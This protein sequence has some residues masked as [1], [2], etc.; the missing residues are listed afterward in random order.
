MILSSV[1]SAPPPAKPT[2]TVPKVTTPTPTATPTT[3]PTSTTDFVIPSSSLTPTPTPN[4]G[5]IPGNATAG[6]CPPPLLPNIYSLD[7]DSCK[8]PCCL[9]CPA[10]SVFY[11][12]GQLET[13]YTITSYLRAV[14]AVS[15]LLLFLAYVVLPSRRKHPHLLVL[16]FAA[17]MVPFEGL[18]T[19]WLKQKEE[20][21]CKN[22]YE[23]TT[24]ANSWFCGVQG[25][26]FMYLVLTILCLATLLITNL[27]LLTV[28]RSALIQD[29]LG[30]LMVLSFFLPLSL[31]LP[32]ALRKQI[33]NPGFGSVCFVSPE[34]ASAY[35][36]LPLSVMVCIATLLHLWTIAF[37]IKSRIQAN[38]VSVGD[39]TS[40]N[41]SDTH[42]NKTLSVRQRRLQTA[43]DISHLLKQQWRPGLL[44]LCLL[45]TDMIYWLFYFTEAKKL[46]KIDASTQWFLQ[47]TQCL[48]QQ[49]LLSIQSGTLPLT[50]TP[51]PAEFQAAGEV[52][53][54]ACASIAEPFVPNFAWAVLAEM[55]P[56]SFG[57]AILFIF[58]T[59]LE[60]WQD[61]R[62]RLWGSKDSTVFIM[63][64]IS[65]DTKDKNSQVQQQ[66]Q[67]QSGQHKPQYNR[68]QHQ[69]QQTDEFY[70]DDLILDQNAYGSRDI[71]A[72]A[73]EGRYGGK[74]PR[75]STSLAGSRTSVPNAQHAK[76]SG[77]YGGPVRKTSVCIDDS[78]EPIYYRP[79]SLENAKNNPAQRQQQQ[80]YLKSQF[81]SDEIHH[82]EYARNVTNGS[83]PW[84]SWPS[85]TRAIPTS[86]NGEMMM[87]ERKPQ[88]TIKTQRDSTY[89]PYQSSIVSPRVTSPMSS[90]MSAPMS[91]PMSPHK[92]FYNSDDLTAPPIPLT[93]LSSSTRGVTTSVD[94]EPLAIPV[95]GSSRREQASSSSFSSD[96]ASRSGKYPSQPTSPTSPTR[97]FLPPV[98]QKSFRRS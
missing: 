34:I 2:T 10:S 63:G 35:F 51:T 62:V 41:P 24:M 71:L 70:S 49:A 59:K 87:A 92:A 58:G 56:A 94:A 25:I 88:P 73:T 33:Q 40:N 9:P 17:L 78:R 82:Q 6:A 8:G 15:C 45:I 5:V 91:A 50:T 61:L 38:A 89:I 77:E 68:G 54:R 12:P 1:T 43:R 66:H 48:G 72:P 20:V 7:S 57:I 11:A 95:R 65:K 32:V 18:G 22:V 36:F 74:Q 39:S 44:A 23:I 47:W 42:S 80:H 90:L 16:V 98:P 64:E 97:A 75:S 52:A 13:I 93:N 3:A 28:H 83:E 27:H 14:S 81:N 85:S 60:L 37:M 53:Q 55:T 21:L 26:A 69:Q 67:H 79:P 96:G 86:N 19:A 84:P 30:K 46:E 31:V 29:H 4:P 76:V